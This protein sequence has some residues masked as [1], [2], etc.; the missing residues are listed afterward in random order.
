MSLDNVFDDAE[1]AAWAER[2]E[3][4]AGGPVHYLCE[5]KVDGLAVNLTYEKG[6]LVRA[7]TR[8]DGRTGEDV[9]A[10]VRTIAGLPERLRG[11][12]VPEFVEMRGEIYFPVAAFADLNAALVEQGKTPFVN[13][14]N[15]AAG[16][17]G[18]R[19]RGRPRAARCA[20][21]CTASA[22][23]AA[24]PSRRSRRR[25]R[26][27]A[28]G[29]ADQRPLAGRVGHRR[30]A[31]VRHGL[32]DHRHT[33]STRSTAWWSRWTRSRPAPARLDQ[34]GAT[35]GDRL[36]IPARRGHSKLLE[37]GSMSG[38]PAGSPRSPSRAGA[39][40]R[41]HGRFATLHNAG[42]VRRKGVRSATRS[43]SARPVT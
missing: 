11:D 19:I 34:P 5:L 2:V 27:S 36:Q 18:R 4:D 43:S 24:S 28:L 29:S 13:P 37:I 31:R 30:G 17:C 6:R 41:V 10:N 42:E 38:G 9:T 8:G 25:T 35:V 20:S 21:S 14:R 40:R 39:G 3:R 7:A 23:A 15:S 12:D 33:S 32:R 1:L 16:S 22:L 26:R